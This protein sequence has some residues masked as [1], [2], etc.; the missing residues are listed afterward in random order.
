MAL[1][2]FHLS[3]WSQAYTFSSVKLNC[4]YKTHVWSR[5]SETPRGRLWSW[6]RYIWSSIN[7]H[8]WSLGFPMWREFL[9]RSCVWMWTINS[10]ESRVCRDWWSASLAKAESFSSN[11][12]L[13]RKEIRQRRKEGMTP[14]L[15]LASTRVLIHRD[16]YHTQSEFSHWGDT[17]TKWMS[18]QWP[19]HQSK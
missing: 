15:P 18:Y 4:L 5:P 6:G 1:L 8:L 11:E 19:E 9:K 13:Y 14:C 2:K 3:I 10:W 12:R 17:R 16:I 7:R